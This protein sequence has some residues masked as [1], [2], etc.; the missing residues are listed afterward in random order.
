MTNEE[1]Q[2]PA[3]R[4]RKPKIM[5]VDVAMAAK[6]TAPTVEELKNK[7]AEM[8]QRRDARRSG[9]KRSYLSGCVAGLKF[10]LGE[11]GPSSPLFHSVTDT[12]AN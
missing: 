8:E 7:L 10:A 4:G 3:K 2:I 12:P 9:K 6:T 1:K 11:L 5:G